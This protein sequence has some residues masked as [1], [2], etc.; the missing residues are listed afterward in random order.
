MINNYSKVLTFL[1]IVVI[2]V[3]YIYIYMHM[4]QIYKINCKIDVNIWHVHRYVT[5]HKYHCTVDNKSIMVR[6]QTPL[7]LNSDLSPLQC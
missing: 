6:H 2:H 5:L 3:A 1:D 7:H 4:K